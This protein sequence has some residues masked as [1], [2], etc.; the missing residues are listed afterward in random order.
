MKIYRT[1]PRASMLIESMRDI[2]Y[3]LETAL[4]DVVDNSISAGATKI[5]LFVDNEDSPR[6]GVLDDGSGMNYEELMAAMRPGSRNPLEERDS[7]DLGRFGLGLKTASFSQCRRLTVVSRKQGRTHAAIWDLQYVA[8]TDDW[9]VQIP[10]NVQDIPW[11]TLLGSSGTLVIWEALDR[12]LEN[13]SSDKGNARL[14]ERMDDA[15]KHL[16]LVFHRF[17]TG[18]W[19]RKKIDIFLNNRRLHAFDPFN[20]RHPATTIG[21]REHIKVGQSIVTI[22]TYT[23]PH[24]KKVTPDEWKRYAGREGY[25]KNQGFYVYRADRL[26]IY[27]TWFGLA[28]QTEL[29]KL[30]RVKIDMPNDVDANW[31]IDV[32][33]ASA[34]PPYQV[35][36]RLKKIID[37]IGSTSK[38]IYT[39]RGRRIA[40]NNRLPVWNRIQDKN[41]ITYKINSKHPVVDDFIKQLPENLCN[42]FHRI[43][44]LTESALPLDTLFADIGNAPESVSVCETTDE[45]IDYVINTTIK[46]LRDGGISWDDI[47]EM[48]QVAEPFS[49]NWDY[50][51]DVIKEIAE[52]GD[53]AVDD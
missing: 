44:E 8:M 41:L 28:K 36:Q 40:S 51:Q 3:S 7:R 37:E 20:E 16:E 39:K 21:P 49:S 50:T 43:L 22:Q 53:Y 32:K 4:A 1:V 11:G 38:R 34:Q 14:I 35:R 26:I 46:K 2:G 29:T 48:M 17:L 15:R 45:T 12:V 13:S 52:K 6:I 47:T 5:E 24:H 33:K 30:T 23:L 9:L 25:L 31:K 18:T 27:G 10:E 42:A 19:N